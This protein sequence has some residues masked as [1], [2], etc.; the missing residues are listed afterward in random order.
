MYAGQ[1]VVFAGGVWDLFHVGHLRFLQKAKSYGDILIVAVSTDELVHRYKGVYPAFSFD[2]RC[3]IVEAL[4]CVDFV[5]GQNELASVELL[6][7]LD[8]DVFVTGDDW[9]DK[10]DEP[11]GYKWIRGNLQMVFLPRTEGISSSIIKGKIRST[12]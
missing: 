4:E 10:V 3:E 2:E 5:V 12:E 6:K 8:V 11:E 7:V 9:K 1:T